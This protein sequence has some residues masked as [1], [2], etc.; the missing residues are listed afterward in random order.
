MAFQMLEYKRNQV[1]EAISHLLEPTSPQ[2]ILK[3]VM[4]QKVTVSEGGRMRRVSRVELM[5]LRL[6]NDAARGDPRATKL[7]LELNDRYGQPTEGGVQS[8][9]LSTDDMEILAAYST[10]GL[11]SWTEQGQDQKE[12]ESLDGDGL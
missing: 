10:Q 11:D 7:A 8:G 5:L 9:E 6:V 3:G 4:S 2:P 1:E 12:A